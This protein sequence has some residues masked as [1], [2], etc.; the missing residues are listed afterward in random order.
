MEPL[1]TLLPRAS[2]S[3]S[4][5]SAS[6]P[7]AFQDRAQGQGKYA[8]ATDRNKSTELRVLELEVVAFKVHLTD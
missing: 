2:Q 1:G 5:K 7:F 3:C 8:R 6:V 4:P